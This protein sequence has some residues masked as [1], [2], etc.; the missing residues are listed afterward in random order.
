MQ[1]V[2]GFEESL[3]EQNQVGPLFGC[4]LNDNRFFPVALMNEGHGFSRAASLAVMT[5]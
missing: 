2:D 3:A 5:A 1:L 4:C